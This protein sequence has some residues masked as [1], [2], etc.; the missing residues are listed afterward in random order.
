M[1]YLIKLALFLCLKNSFANIWNNSRMQVVRVVGDFTSFFVTVMVFSE[2][3]QLLDMAPMRVILVLSTTAEAI[4][5]VTEK[6]VM[7]LSAGWQYLPHRS[8]AKCI[9]GKSY[10]R[11][12]KTYRSYYILSDQERLKKALRR[13]KRFAHLSHRRETLLKLGYLTSF[14]IVP[15]SVDLRAGNVREIARGEVYVHAHWSSDPNLLYGLALRRSPWIFD[16][17]FLRRPFYYR[18]EANRMMT[19]FVFENFRLCPLFAI[20]QFGHEVKSA[21]YDAF[22]RLARGLGYDQEEYVCADGTY[23]FDPFAKTILK[24]CSRDSVEMCRPL[25]TDEEVLQDVE[26]CPVPTAFE[27]AETYTFPLKYVQEV[28]LSKIETYRNISWTQSATT[29]GRSQ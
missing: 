29:S 20:Y 4:R 3:Y 12:L 6:G 7:I 17:R 24:R 19:I 18:T 16:P 14:K 15:T 8:I 2:I 21:R 25:W 26:N 28:L 9:P 10:F 22:Y 5:L 1:P 11:F 23:H 13:L 27:I